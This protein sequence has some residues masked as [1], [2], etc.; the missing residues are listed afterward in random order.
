MKKL[1]QLLPHSFRRRSLVVVG[2]IFVRALLNMVGLALL[3][4]ILASALDP[5][6]L[7]GSGMLAR[8]YAAT[9]LR[10]IED[11]A[12]LA[13]T[14]VV[15]II[16]LKCGINYLLARLERRFI[17]DLYG[18]L[19][20]QLFIRYHNEGLPFIKAHNSAVLARNVNV[21]CLSFTAGVLKPLAT[22]CSE[23]MLL[24]LLF[25]ALAC[26]APLAAVMA[27][28]VFVP[29]AW[30]YYRFIRRRI[31]HYGEIENRAQREK[32]RIVAESL[33]GYADIELSG[34]FPMMLSRFEQA[35]REV[36]ATRSKEADLGL[37]PAI[38][39]ELGLA[40]GIALLSVISLSAG[41]GSSRLIFGI[42]AVAALRM[43]P[44]VRA[45][46]SSWTTLRYN[47]YSIDILYEAEASKQPLTPLNEQTQPL[48]FDHEITLHDLSFT[49]P[50][51]NTPLFEHLSLAIRKGEHVGFRGSSGSGKTTLFNLLIGF[52]TP[53]HGS[54]TIDGVPLSEAN[55][56]SWQQRLGYVS[57]SL[58]LI[59]GT[60]AENVAP[61]IA[62]EAMDRTRIDEVLRAAQLGELIDSLPKGID[63]PIG[64][65]GCR[66]SGGQRQRIGIARALYRRADVLLLD[67]ATSALDSQT[68]QEINQT[69][70]SLANEQRD[71]TV[72]VIAHREASLSDCDRI[73]TI[74]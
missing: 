61:G 40:I 39:T 51:S 9:G 63:T 20:K 25:I 16:A 6:M 59:D 68:E 55:R 31:N 3:L 37:L 5:S 35:M 57:Q 29:A 1:L 67:E 36:I 62:P 4:P 8:I 58:F 17:Y 22:I 72:L 10:S 26:Y 30:G 45:L 33:R 32:A 27:L 53:T 13:A 64:E 19:S 66:L 43:M 14:A 49:F 42:F 38:I 28:L 41:E 44:A 54:I 2:S 18:T 48:Q 70:R 60:L 69:I 24:G 34:A 21:V 46:M 47:R 56:R 23:C 50:D 65:C 52:Y 7:V 74:E 73:I 15:G 71:L 11:F 12:L